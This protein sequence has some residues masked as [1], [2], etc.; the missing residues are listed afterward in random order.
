MK[1]I[2]IVLAALAF[3]ACGTAFAQ[4]NLIAD[5]DMEGAG[6]ATWI[7]EGS[8]L[9]LKK[10]TG[11]A[12]STALYVRG[13]YNWSGL[14]RDVTKSFVASSDAV[15][16]IEASFKLDPA[17]KAVRHADVSLALQPAGVSEEDYDS[18]IYLTLD[19]DDDKYSGGEVA[20]NNKDFVKVN[21]IIS[22]E[23]AVSELKGRKVVNA[24]IYFKI[25]NALRPYY[26]DNVVFKKIK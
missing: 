2:K 12:G 22:G 21:G 5:G 6:V 17:D 13:K 16:Y 25:D 3:L 20:L 24:T 18:F 8:T 9:T 1:K 15:Y 19:S 7:A 26:V 14:G 23:E 10:G 11:V 4:Q